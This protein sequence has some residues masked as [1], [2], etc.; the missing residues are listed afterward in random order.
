ML[1]K[2]EDKAYSFFDDNRQRI[3]GLLKNLFSFFEKFCIS[4]LRT[5][6]KMVV[7]NSV[8]CII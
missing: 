1:L 6:K 5:Q 8:L 3:C 2:T 7:D 4:L